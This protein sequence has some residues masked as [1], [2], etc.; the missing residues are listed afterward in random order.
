M[1]ARIVAM[2]AA[3]ETDDED[4]RSLDQAQALSNR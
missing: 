2:I 1:T 4:Q 3:R